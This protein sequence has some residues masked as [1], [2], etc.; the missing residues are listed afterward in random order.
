MAHN[1][2]KSRFSRDFLLLLDAVALV[3]CSREMLQSL[4]FFFSLSGISVIIF[5]KGVIFFL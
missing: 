3:T 1:T 4:S 5:E 2:K